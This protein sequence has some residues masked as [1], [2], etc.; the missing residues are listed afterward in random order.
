MWLKLST[1]PISSIVWGGIVLGILIFVHELGHFLAAK[2]LG[3]K[4]QKFSLGFGPSVISRRFGETEYA[5]SAFPLG[6]YV[7][8]MGE[9]PSES[10]KEEE[11]HRSFTFKKTWQKI[12][13]VAAGPGFNLLF[14]LLIFA[15][16][17]NI[18][19]PSLSTEIGGVKKGFPAERAGLRASDVIIAVDGEPVKTWDE[20]S[21]A[22]K[23]RKGETI[24]ITVDRKGEV[25]K[26]QIKPRITVVKDLFGRNV[27]TP[28]L[29][30][31]SSGKVIVERYGPIESIYKGAKETIRIVWLTAVTVKMLILRIL[32]MDTLGGPILIAQLASKQA[33]A[34]VLS[35]LFFM[36]LLS[37]NLGILNLLPIPVLDGGNLLFFVIEA[38]SGKTIKGRVKEAAQQLGFFF[39]LLLIALVF[40]NDIGRIWKQ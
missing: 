38:I 16:L 2:K 6:G 27:E 35:L 34:G 28:L 10:I 19:V 24:N 31:V 39:L 13:I 22:I 17:F 33:Q 5:I 25:L 1:I 32:P 23:R 9:D 26:L 8:M 36:G 11:A 12:V 15:L 30:I 29:G 18:G 3:V 20:L 21:S 14:A 4:V 37:V 7:K 40:Y